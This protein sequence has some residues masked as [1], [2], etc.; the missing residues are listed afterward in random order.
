MPRSHARSADDILGFELDWLA[1]DADGHV[2]MFSTA[3]GGYAPEAFLRDTDAHDAAID[4]IL[5][6]PASTTARFAPELPAGL[7]NTWREIAER[8]VF[9]FDSDAHGRP[10]RLVA[11]PEA[12]V[13]VA[14]L[15][16]RAAVVVSSLVLSRL[17][18][19]DLPASVPDELLQPRQDTPP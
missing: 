12:P 8:G 17:S 2:A 16:D 10:Y 1:S 15:P 13:R 18:L 6:A 9:A 11:V 4:A 19:A 5:A 3:G 7:R 14:A